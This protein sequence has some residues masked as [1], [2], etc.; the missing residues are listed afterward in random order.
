LIAANKFP[1]PASYAGASC[2]GGVVLPDDLSWMSVDKLIAGSQLIE[3]TKPSILDNAYSVIKNNQ[4]LKRGIVQIVMSTLLHTGQLEYLRRSGLTRGEWKIVVEVH[5]YY[6]RQQSGST[7][8]KDTLGQTLFVNLNY[9]TEHEIA[10]PEYI[11]N[12]A[13]VA[14]HEGRIKKSLPP[15]FLAHLGEVRKGLDQPT[16]IRATTIPAHGVVSF[17]DE[18]IHH[19]TPRYGH[20]TVRAEE[21]ET[22]LKDKWGKAEYNKSYDAALSVYNTNENIPASD[23]SWLASKLR[24]QVRWIEIMKSKG[25][26]RAKVEHQGFK[27]RYNRIQLSEIGLSDALINELIDKYSEKGFLKTSIPR[28]DKPLDPILADI[29]DPGTEPLK[30]QMSVRALSGNLPPEVTGRR[31]FFRIW[32]RAVPRTANL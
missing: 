31:A 2:L 13:L 6:Q 5:Y 25:D 21:L 8:H 9:L 7:F 27:H 11:L 30:R 20:R 32:V 16:E 10:G 17:V 28:P 3:L 4:Y 26:T 12:P 1:K 14:E 24:Q 22:F 19:M 23:S 29:R 18:L 15:A